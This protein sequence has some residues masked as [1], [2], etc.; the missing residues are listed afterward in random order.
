MARMPFS[1]AVKLAE[2]LDI[3]DLLRRR[4]MPENRLRFFNRLLQERT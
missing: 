4:S 3:S 2:R 1:D